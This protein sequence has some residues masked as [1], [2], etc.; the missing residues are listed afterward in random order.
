LCRRGLGKTYENSASLGKS[1]EKTSTK[2]ELKKGWIG[3]SERQLGF[4]GGQIFAKKGKV[5]Q[6]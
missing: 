3:K 4:P 5:D 1:Q 6:R 2:D